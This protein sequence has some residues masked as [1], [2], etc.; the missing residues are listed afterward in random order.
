MIQSTLVQSDLGACG[1]ARDKIRGVGNET[2][3]SPLRLAAT[4]LYIAAWP[5]LMFL[6]A[7]GVRWPE[8]WLFAGWYVGL[9]GT[10]ILWLYRKD[11]ALLAERYRRPGSGGQSGWDKVWV[12]SM[13]V[14]FAVWIA[15]MPLDARRFH[16]TPP[17]SI[18]PKGLGAMLLFA[19]SFLFFRAFHDNTF[20]SPLVRIQTERK[21]RVVSTGVYGFV[22]HPMYLGA[23][24][25]FTG[26]PL[27]LGSVVGLVIAGVMTLLLAGRIVGE[28]R[29]LVEQ[30]DGY[31]DYQRSVRYRLVPFVW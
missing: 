13:V 17:F 12:Y 26:A 4:A 27:L 31:A 30:L 1:R 20:L 16:W 9:C 5:A 10:V 2:P 15:A 22:R 29:M 8:G 21:Q 23:V 7:G 24:L 14:G 19:S 11:P 3:V 18:W 25:L 6:L 28:E